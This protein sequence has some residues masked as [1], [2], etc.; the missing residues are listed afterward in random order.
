M[1]TVAGFAQEEETAAPEVAT[2]E[3]V[4]EVVAA[5]PEKEKPADVA[6]VEQMR[7]FGCGCGKSKDGKP[8]I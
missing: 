5:E 4:T 3:V 7:D 6:Q 2:T 8:K 1:V